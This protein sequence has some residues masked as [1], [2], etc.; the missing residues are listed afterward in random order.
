MRTLAPV[1]LLLLTF[2]ACGRPPISNLPL[3]WSGVDHAPNATTAVENAF[4]RVPFT[5]V[6][7]KDKRE[8]PTA[9]GVHEGEAFVVRTTDDV[10][11]Y[12]SGRFKDM[13]SSAGARLD[14]APLAKVTPELLEYKVVEG[15]LFNGYVRFRVTVTRGGAAPW[16]K[17]YSG[18]SKRRGRTHN[19]E[20]FNEALSNAL[21]EA[22]RKMVQDEAFANALDGKA[23]A[24][25]PAPAQPRL[26]PQTTQTTGTPI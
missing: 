3:A 18:T 16:T 25:E 26:A 13:L 19:P 2:S 17:T 10:A 6:D 22:T 8:D 24:S 15:G 4:G 11:K 20:N 5:L 14:A 21:A 12:C 9:V 1:A 7:F 23:Q